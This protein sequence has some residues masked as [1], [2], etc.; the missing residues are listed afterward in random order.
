MEPAVLDLISL[1]LDDPTACSQETLLLS[2][3]QR[4]PG[5]NEACAN[6]ELPV[7]AMTITKILVWISLPSIGIRASSTTSVM[8]SSPRGFP[9]VPDESMS[10]WGSRLHQRCLI[11]S[12]CR[13]ILIVQ[14]MLAIKHL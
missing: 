13:R 14:Q 7:E 2:L 9:L 11:A 8:S 1:G 5:I 4:H 10:F 3:K 6:P 12:I